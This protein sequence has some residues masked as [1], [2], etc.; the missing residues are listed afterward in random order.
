M[1]L[2]MLLTQKNMST[3]QCSK[4]SGIPYTTLL[5]LV[6]GKTSIEKCAAETVYRL[7]SAL[8]MTMDEL[9][10]RLHTSGT[11][12]SFETF[13]SNLCH[14]VKEKGDLSFIIETLEADDIGRYW[15]RKWYPEAYY[16]L[17]MVDYLSR[18]NQLPLCKNY[19][20]IRGTSL[21]ETIYP[22][23]IELAASL[24]PSLDVRK[25]SVAESIPEFIRFNIVEKEI[26]NVC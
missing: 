25:Q 7:A 13:K 2:A 20:S 8:D 16:T 10:K 24:D 9:Y 26:R 15:S 18:E 11:R 14:I 23:D 6:K 21:K 3:Y 19:D 4:L 5:E 22:R 17:A 12:V 1:Q